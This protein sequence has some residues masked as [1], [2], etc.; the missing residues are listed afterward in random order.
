MPLTPEERRT[1]EELKARLDAETHSIHRLIRYWV[2]VILTIVVFGSIVHL[3][4]DSEARTRYNKLDEDFLAS[5]AHVNPVYF[6][7]VYYHY[8][9]ES[10][11]PDYNFL[12]NPFQRVMRIFWRAV[13]TGVIFTLWSIA[14]EG[15]P[16]AVLVG[17]A[18]LLPFVPFFM[19]DDF[20]VPGGVIKKWLVFVATVA[21]FLSIL[22][23]FAWFIGLFVKGFL[24][25][26]G[27]L[28]SIPFI[29]GLLL[30]VTEHHFSVKVIKRLAKETD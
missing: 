28:V 15:W 16:N 3:A 13:L 6:A 22:Y 17:I 1:Y 9:V 8:V 21:V 30:K 12:M 19:N 14:K 7:N 4:S 29:G 26:L 5:L 18:I 10:P 20:V 23:P 27:T 2:V 25:L 24:Q 11:D